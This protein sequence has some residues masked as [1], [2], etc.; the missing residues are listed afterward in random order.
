MGGGTN[1][2]DSREISINISGS[3]D[4]RARQQV[5]DIVGS[6]PEFINQ[7][8]KTGGEYSTGIA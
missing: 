6:E 2:V 7:V 3:F 8:A 1:Y 5:M 4:E